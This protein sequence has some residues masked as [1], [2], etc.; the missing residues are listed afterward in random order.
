M[1]Y[2]PPSVEQ[3][4]HFLITCKKCN[5]ITDVVV[6]FKPKEYWMGLKCNKCKTEAKY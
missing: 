3:N 6:V 1:E 4:K 5:E 2:T